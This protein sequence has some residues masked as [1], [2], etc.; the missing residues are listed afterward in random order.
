MKQ[1][2]FMLLLVAIVFMGSA[3]T[4][5]NAGEAFEKDDDIQNNVIEDLESENAE[6]E[7]AEEDACDA[8]SGI[9]NGTGSMIVPS[10]LSIDENKI[11][12]QIGINWQTDVAD[13]DSLGA[14]Q[15]KWPDLV[16]ID[17]VETYGGNRHEVWQSGLSGMR[18]FLGYWKASGS[19]GTDYNYNNLIQYATG[20]A[21]SLIT[22]LC[23]PI[24]TAE[25]MSL[26]EIPE[27]D[28]DIGRPPPSPGFDNYS[29]NY[30]T[31]LFSD[32]L[33][34]DLC[35]VFMPEV[36]GKD[37]LTGVKITLSKPGYVSPADELEIRL[38]APQP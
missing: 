11:D 22:G 30:F 8:D 38:V 9:D 21:N 35:F 7:N 6:T 13:T 34:E 31:F 5:N 19:I 17:S 3:C 27:S 20:Q 2:I 18:Y 14:L 4:G 26:L 36:N 25:L 37:S 29:A 10:Q 15:E 1:P 23:A 33:W 12:L 32:I 16:L 24:E 28:W